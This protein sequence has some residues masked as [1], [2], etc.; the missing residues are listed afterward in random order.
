M[1]IENY[2]YIWNE[3]KMD[4]VLVKTKLGHSIVNKRRKNICIELHQNSIYL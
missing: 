1:C 4:Y 2:S 3:Q